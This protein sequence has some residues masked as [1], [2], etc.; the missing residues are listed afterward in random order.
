MSQGHSSNRPISRK[1][2]LPLSL[3]SGGFGRKPDYNEFRQD[4]WRVSG[5]LSDA[6]LETEKVGFISDS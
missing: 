1:R 6:E 4:F 2:L 3:L 5:F